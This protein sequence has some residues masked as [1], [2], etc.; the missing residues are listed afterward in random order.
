MDERDAVRLHEAEWFRIYVS[1]RQVGRSPEGAS[2]RATREL[3][4][5]WSWLADELWR[6]M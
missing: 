3:P 5:L 2:I 6:E 1:H 4:P